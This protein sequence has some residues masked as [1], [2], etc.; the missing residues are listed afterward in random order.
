LHVEVGIGFLEAVLDEEIEIVSLIE[1]LALDVRVV[2]PELT[3]LSV[4]LCDE[5]LTH[6]R[7]LNVHIV[8]RQIEVRPEVPG[9]L[10]VVIP[11]EGKR[12]RLVLPIDRVEVEE[13][14]EFSFAVVSE[15]C[16]FGL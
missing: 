1:D 2:L 11:F 3:N 12:M 15:L 10:T 9:R 13:S 5:L 14:R 6:R 8:F 4:L 7:D 16:R